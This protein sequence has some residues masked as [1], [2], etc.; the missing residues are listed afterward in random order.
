MTTRAISNKHHTHRRGAGCSYTFSD[1]LSE[2]IFSNT[3][4]V[5]LC[6]CLAALFIS[7]CC[8]SLSAEGSSTPTYKYY[9][10]VEVQNGDTV[11]T[12]AN[13]NMGDEYASVQE[14]IEEVEAINHID[15]DTITT[16]QTLILPYYSTELQ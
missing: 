13:H 6:I 2:T 7:I 12:I 1:Y 4:V 9:K 3:R 10:S 16:G 14:Y 15:A 8:F 5:L 11:W